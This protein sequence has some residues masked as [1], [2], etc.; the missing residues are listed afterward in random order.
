VYA[1]GA[2]ATAGNWALGDGNVVTFNGF[3]GPIVWNAAGTPGG[4]SPAP[5][6]SK[7]KV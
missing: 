6:Q 3:T 1:G 7:V 4:A 5:G 2:S